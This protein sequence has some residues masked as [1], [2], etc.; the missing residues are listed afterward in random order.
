MSIFWVYRVAE[1]I[2]SEVESSSSSSLSSSGSEMALNPEYIDY[3]GRAEICE[4][5][6]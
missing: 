6:N 3:N 2:P 4:L 1:L 5:G